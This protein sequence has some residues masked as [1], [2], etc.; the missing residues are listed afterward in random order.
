MYNIPCTADM[1]KQT[2]LPLAVSI[3]PFA[4]L[5]PKEVRFKNFTQSSL[6]LLLISMLSN[7]KPKKITL[8]NRSNVR[9]VYSSIHFL[10]C[11]ISGIYIY[12]IIYIGNLYLYQVSST[13]PH[14]FPTFS[15]CSTYSQFS[16]DKQKKTLVNS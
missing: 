15:S 2:Q 1:L 14:W 8:M 5:H 7:L 13:D 16:Q 9:D 10:N 3:T 6:L 4:R 11:V 12:I